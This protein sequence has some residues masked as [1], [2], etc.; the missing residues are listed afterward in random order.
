MLFRILV[1]GLYYQ[2]KVHNALCQQA[3][4]SFTDLLLNNNEIVFCGL[5]TC[6]IVEIHDKPAKNYSVSNIYLMD[7]QKSSSSQ[8]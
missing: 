2:F 1:S 6:L 8:R 3:N 5:N 4:Y 7:L